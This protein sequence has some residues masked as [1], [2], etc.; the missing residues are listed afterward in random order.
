M[1]NGVE[2]LLNAI[3]ECGSLRLTESVALSTKKTIIDAYGKDIFEQFSDFESSKPDDLFLV[4]IFTDSV[5]FDGVDISSNGM[6]LLANGGSS[7]EV[8]H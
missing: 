2:K 6:R 7:E 8:F 5:L 1:M 4:F 3:R